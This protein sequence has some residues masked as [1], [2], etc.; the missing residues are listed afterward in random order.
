MSVVAIAAVLAAMLIGVETAAA[1]SCQPVPAKKQLRRA[2]GAFNGRLLSVR[3]V[4]GTVEVIFRY[5]VR[6]AFKGPFRRGDVVAVRTQNICEMPRG[7]G[8]VYGLFVF[9]RKGGWV[10][11]ACG[12]LSPRAMR[13]AAE[14]G[15]SASPSS[16]A[17]GCPS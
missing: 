8:D 2:D 13:R 10:S 12:V 3:P 5:R 15:S 6:R 4:E 9:R 1:C 7:I 11:G 16:G 14:T 17:G